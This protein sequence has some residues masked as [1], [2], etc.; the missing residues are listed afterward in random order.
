MM[1][2]LRN[3]LF[4][5]DSEDDVILMFH[6]IKQVFSNS[7]YDWA[8]SK[9]KLIELLN[10]EKNWDIII[11]DNSLPQLFGHEAVTMI[12]EKDIQTPIICVS[13]SGFLIDEDKCLQ[14]GAVKFISKS[15]LDDLVE[16]VK[17]FSS[18]KI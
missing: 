11:C 17:E 4:I 16:A 9:I 10:S 12:R 18:K 8:D 2:E 3:I 15:N 5:E 7:D 1:N 14:A 13:G 6:Y